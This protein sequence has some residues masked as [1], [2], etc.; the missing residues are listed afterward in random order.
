MMISA[1]HPL[2]GPHSASTALDRMLCLTSRSTKLRSWPESNTA[3]RLLPAVAFTAG[4]LSIDTVGGRAERVVWS[5]FGLT[6][7][8]GAAGQS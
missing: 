8:G 3:S 7:A 5:L 4:D 1:T 2:A 6:A